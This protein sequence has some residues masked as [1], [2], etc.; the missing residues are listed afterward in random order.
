[1]YSHKQDAA[2]LIVCLNDSDIKRIP[3][4]VSGIMYKCI[5]ESHV[6]FPVIYHFIIKMKPIIYYPSEVKRGEYWGLGVFLLQ[7]SPLVK[8]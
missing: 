3:L 5:N 4:I 6:K 2:S 1:M 8:I 7:N